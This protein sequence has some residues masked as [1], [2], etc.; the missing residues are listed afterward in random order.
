MPSL[1]FAAARFADLPELRKLRHIFVG[2]YGNSL[3]SFV[4]LEV[5]AHTSTLNRTFFVHFFIYL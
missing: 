5:I 2:R 3:E 4:N 1:M